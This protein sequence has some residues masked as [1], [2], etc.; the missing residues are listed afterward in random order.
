MSFLDVIGSAVGSA[1]GNFEKALKTERRKEKK[2][3]EAMPAKGTLVDVFNPFQ[4][5]HGYQARPSGLDY[6]ALR[7]I[8]M[9]FPIIASIIRTRVNQAAAFAKIPKD[10]FD[11]GFR[12]RPRDDKQKMTR[13]V[14]KVSD[15][16]TEFLLCCGDPKRNREYTND[17]LQS[18]IRKQVR[19]SLIFDQM[20]MQVVPLLDGTPYELLAMPAHTMRLSWDPR[21]TAAH[22]IAG[23]AA[24]DNST[25]GVH[26]QVEI[27]KQDPA[28]PRY[29]QIYQNVPIADFTSYELSW[30][31]RNPRS[32]IEVGEYGYSELEELVGVLTQLASADSY[33]ALLYMQGAMSDGFL[34]F[35]EGN[36]NKDQ[37]REFARQWRIQV[38]GVENAHRMPIMNAPGLEW[39]SMGR[40]SQKDME[41]GKYYDHLIRIACAIFQIDPAE[42]NFVYGNVGQASSLNQGSAEDK[43]KTS[44]D[45]GLR[46]I[47]SLLAQMLTQFVVRRFNEDF[48]LEFTGMNPETEMERIEKISKKVATVMTVNEGRKEMGL[49][50]RD[51]CEVILDP[52]WLQAKQGA[53][54]ADQGAAGNGQGNGL[55]DKMGNSGGPF[56]GPKGGKWKDPQHTV[57]WDAVSKS[58][59]VHEFTL[60]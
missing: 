30:G 53:E 59:T 37:I 49:E 44:R 16:I 33:N 56:V 1:F 14:K 60:E 47:M 17:S 58:V 7:K 19:D 10:D 5:T 45:R 35:K 38:M 20:N 52:V 41:F 31:V 36:I 22:P 51:D 13:G 8:A 29:V 23:S 57:P 40:M 27:P 2:R 15:E 26:R 39:I 48:T 9:S 54:M 18:L 32:D 42:I 6:D 24:F 50:E 3:T 4:V 25:G 11:L 21:W 28:A 12:V 43:I 55:F 46:P 34:N